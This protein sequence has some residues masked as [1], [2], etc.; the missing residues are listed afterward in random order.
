MTSNTKISDIRK[1]SDFC[2]FLSLIEN[3]EIKSSIGWRF[4]ANNVFITSKNLIVDELTNTQKT[5]SFLQNNKFDKDFQI[6]DENFCEIADIER[7]IKNIAQN[8]VLNDIELFEVKKFVL[9]SEK[10]RLVTDNI[11]LIEFPDL[12]KV[13]KILDP[14]N[15]SM[16]TFYI[17]DV[18]SAE[19]AL[20]RKRL[21]TEPSQ[22]LQLQILELEQEIR[23]S[24]SQKLKPFAGNLLVAL[25]NA[26]CLDLLIAKA[27]FA[28][29]YELCQPQIVENETEYSQIFNPE[30]KET[31]ETLGRKYQKIDIAFSDHPVLIT[32]INM[33]GKTLLLKTL[34]LSQM[35]CQYGF[36]VPAKTAKISLVAKVMFSF[37]DEQNQKQGLSSFAAEMLNMNE[38]ITQISENQNILVLIDELARTTN[39]KEGAAIVS[40]ML[41]ILSEKQIKSF[42]TTHYDI[43]NATCCRLRVKGF[44]DNIENINPK[45]IE[46][47]IDY[48]LI[49]D[50]S[51]KTPQQAFRIAELLNINKILIEKAK[52]KL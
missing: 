17:Y 39:P 4:F 38:I 35:L 13:V 7:T 10:I 9:I 30:I 45:N 50:N 41:E 46:Q 33:G 52:K 32:G 2:G 51:N 29:K 48:Q 28:L 27:K 36:Y 12:S 8:I 44:V 47:F 15:T 16:P 34:A 20:L 22:D 6:L 23:H 18:Y 37:T 19:L 26:A 21:K 1:Y 40:A 5:I 14:E 24:L 11:K 31:L 42:I 3:L 25:N 49:E 43:H